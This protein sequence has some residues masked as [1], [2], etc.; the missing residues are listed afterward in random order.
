MCGKANKRIGRYCHKFHF[1]RDDCETKDMGRLFQLFMENKT[2]A[3]FFFLFL[4]AAGWVIKTSFNVT[5]EQQKA[6]EVKR[7]AEA[8]KREQFTEKQIQIY[9]EF[10]SRLRWFNARM[11][12]GDVPGAITAFDQPSGAFATS[13][14][15]LAKL[16]S[17]SL[18]QGAIP[19]SERDQLPQVWPPALNTTKA[20]AEAQ[21]S[22]FMAI[23]DRYCGPHQLAN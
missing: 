2:V 21:I 23:V 15:E 3:T 20:Q 4:S 16:N 7:L 13:D 14:P 9:T 19:P 10:Q 8:G 6:L 11:Q 18:L 5:H 22:A 1:G 17:L 12:A